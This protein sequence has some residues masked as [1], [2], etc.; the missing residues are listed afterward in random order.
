[1]KLAE[2]WF[3]QDGKV[4]HQRTFDPNQALKAARNLRDAGGDLVSD[5]KTIGVVPGW[6]WAQWLK[7]AGV[8]P[9]DHDAAREVLD[10]KLMSGE[11]ANLRVW[12]GTY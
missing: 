6:L 1:M 7:E 4:I 11:F 3:E 8:K 9:S 10:R 5:S 2:K 12:G